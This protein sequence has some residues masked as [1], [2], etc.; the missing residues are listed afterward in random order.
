MNSQTSTKQA[1]AGLN[2]KM[3]KSAENISTMK[4][5]QNICNDVP[6]ISSPAVLRK[7]LGL[8]MHHSSIILGKTGYHV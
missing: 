6:A 3:A 8:S 7:S 4:Q 5:I 1:K 2:K